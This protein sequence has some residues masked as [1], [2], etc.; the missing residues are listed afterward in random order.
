MKRG[1]TLLEVLI[2]IMIFGILIV[3]LYKTLDNTKYSNKLINEKKQNLINSNKIYN[4]FLEDIL[5]SSNIVILK[6]KNKNSILKM[7]SHN[8]FHNSNF[9]NVTYL[10]D[11]K[12]N[13]IRIESEGEFN[14]EKN[15]DD[16]Y[17]NSYIDILI[18]NIVFFEVLNKESNILISLNVKDKE[19]K[20]YNLSKLL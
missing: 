17:K 11:N 13:L 20:F 7:S 9:N 3:F 15:T 8:I 19:T 2:S 6:D 4:I 16:F 1:F 14:L 5:E 10:I 18:E 12:N